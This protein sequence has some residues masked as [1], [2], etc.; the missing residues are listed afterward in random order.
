MEELLKEINQKLLILIEKTEA[1]KLLSAKEISNIYK[2]N[3][4]AVLEMFKDK[5]LAVQRKLKPQRVLQSE[6]EQYL[7]KSR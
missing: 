1:D 7:K 5:E 6:F 2:I 4:E 3:Y